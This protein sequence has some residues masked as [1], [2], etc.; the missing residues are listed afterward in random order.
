M[1]IYNGVKLVR[2][3]VQILASRQHRITVKG[4]DDGMKCLTSSCE[5]NVISDYHPKYELKN[6]PTPREL[7]LSALGSCTIMT[8][9]THCESKIGYK[10]KDITVDLEEIMGSSQHIPENIRLN[11]NLKYIGTID[12]D[13]A[14]KI[15]SIADKCPVK[16]IIT[17]NNSPEFITSNVQVERILI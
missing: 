3:Y 10:I 4:S 14:K 17:G 12:H 16:R 7:L 1:M 9:K 6:Y 5:W 11:I 15:K 13:T 2:K 8:I